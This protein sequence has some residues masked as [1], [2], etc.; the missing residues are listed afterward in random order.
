[1]R[2]EWPPDE[3]IES[4]TLVGQDWSLVGNK[5]GTTR[6]GFALLLKFFEVEARFPRA[7]EELPDA[8]AGYVA[9]QWPPV[10]TAKPRPR[11]A[12]LRRAIAR[13][14]GAGSRHSCSS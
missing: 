7:A 12:N 14:A 5:T 10:S 6:L 9:D 13:L 2:R 4:W 8:A 1:M 11:C 3:L